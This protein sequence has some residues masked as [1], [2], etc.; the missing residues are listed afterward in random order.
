VHISNTLSIGQI[1]D[2]ICSK[3]RKIITGFVV[4]NCPAKRLI[5]DSN[6]IYL[7][8]D[9]GPNPHFTDEIANL[10]ESRG[11]QATFFVVGSKV[12]KHEGIVK[13]LIAAGHAVGSHSH[14]HKQQWN[15]GFFEIYKDYKLGKRRLDKISHVKSKLFRPPYGYHDICSQL[16]ASLNSQTM[17]LWSC[18]SFDWEET[19]SLESIIDNVKPALYAGNIILLHDAILD[20]PRAADRTHTVAALSVILDELDTRNLVSKGLS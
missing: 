17:I 13:K 20:N 4:R 9:D 16:F 11:H 3:A 1:V 2:R 7:T 19:S 18:D 5:P 10:L 6:C 8:F 14:T 15:H 12:E